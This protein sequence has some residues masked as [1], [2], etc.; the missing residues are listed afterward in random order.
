MARRIIDASFPTVLWARRPEPLELFNATSAERA[1]SRAAVGATVDML[2]VCVL[3]DDGVDEVL[4]G[5]DGALVDMAPGSVVAVH[6]TVH[7]TTCRRL[8]HDFPQIHFVDAPVSGG[9]DKAAAGELV[10]MAGGPE[11]VVERCR[12]VFETYGDPV[13]RVGELGTGLLVKLLNNTLFTAQLALAA[14]VYEHADRLG[15]DQGA[16]ARLL[17]EG[18]GQSYA[19][20]LVAMVGFS[21]DEL[22]A[23]A[24]P[25]LAKDLAILAAN[26]R[27]EGSTLLETAEHALTAMDVWSEEETAR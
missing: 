10:V 22:A 27:T 11:A 4:R 24:A 3:D 6:S 20:G 2:C 26:V 13:V 17:A 7:P 14:E 5:P 25:L 15:V 8:Q 9:G 12:P 1:P 16:V 23:I 21:L 18:S 19:A